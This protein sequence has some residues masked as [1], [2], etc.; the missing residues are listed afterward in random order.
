MVDNFTVGH[1][2]FLQACARFSVMTP[3]QYLDIMKAVKTKYF[4]DENA[5][6]DEDAAV[7]KM[8]DEINAKL[9]ER[10]I[11]QRL[12][13]VHY[14][15]DDVCV[16]FLIFCNTFATIGP[17]PI[18]SEVECNFMKSI[19]EKILMSDT[20]SITIMSAIQLCSTSSQATQSQA[21]SKKITKQRAEELL[22]EWENIG[23]FM[24]TGDIITLG[25][26]A[27]GEFRDTYRTKFGDF[28]Q[29]CFLCNGLVLQPKFC[30]N[31]QCDAVLDKKCFNNYVAKKKK[32]PACKTDWKED[33]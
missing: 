3:N 22:D 27:I 4:N 21:T 25:P 32:C 17:S 19:M 33:A 24:A 13:F 23:Y 28:I 5:A 11:D 16:E 26:R 7:R 8:V 31:D 12:N 9:I 1:Q 20:H 18:A 30:P 14:E 2:A 15:W 29:C 10:E 6:N